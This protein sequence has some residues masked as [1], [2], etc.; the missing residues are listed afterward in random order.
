MEAEVEEAE[1]EEKN[2]QRRRKSREFN[3]YRIENKRYH[4]IG[5]S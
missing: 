3:H 4:E 1:E 5:E 2:G